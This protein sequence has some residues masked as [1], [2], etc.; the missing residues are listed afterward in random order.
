MAWKIDVEFVQLNDILSLLET[1]LSTYSWR[2]GTVDDM[3]KSEHKMLKDLNS[4]L[5][6]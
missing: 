1:V 3:F 5:Q 2:F 4:I 6:S